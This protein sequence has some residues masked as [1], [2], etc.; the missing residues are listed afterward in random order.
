MRKKK[1]FKSCLLLIYFISVITGIQA[2]DSVA[3]K[4]ILRIKYF[5]VDNKVPYLII[6]T[7]YKLG[8]KF[9]PVKNVAVKLYIDS[10]SSDA[11]LLTSV[12]TDRDGLAKAILPPS[13]KELW[14]GS[15]QA[16]FIASSTASKEF[17]EIQTELAVTKSKISLD[18]SSDE[19]GRKI[20]A[21]VTEF[22]NGK[23]VPAKEVEMKIGIRRL[24]SILPVGDDETYT[25][26]STGEAVAEFK[27]D[28]LPGD[29]KGNIVLV[30]KVEENEL[31]GTLVTE[32]SVPWGVY[33]NRENNV[34]KRSLWAT[35]DKVPIWLL[36]MA[37]V[38][39]GGVWGVL[40]Y[41]VFQLYKI[42]KIGRASYKSGLSILFLFSLL[43]YL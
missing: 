27:K 23:W 15:A 9:T 16:N 42:I 5:S 10:D 33:T 36:F 18:T 1:I 31:Y 22:K 43:H 12:T 17:D 34:A 37:Y 32:K 19:Q 40:F 38:I 39:A 13:V 30:A 8:K 29:E 35:G 24:N 21:T 7:Q 25:T 11:N 14:H 4:P 28:R 41:L 20:T 6:Q 26:D 3:K 2:Q